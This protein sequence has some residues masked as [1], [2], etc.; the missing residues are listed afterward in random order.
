MT[1]VRL[2][3]VAAL[4]ALLVATVLLVSAAARWVAQRPAFEFKRIEVRGDLQHVTAASVRAAIAAVSMVWV[5]SR[6]GGRPGSP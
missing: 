4:A 3:N 6:R 5:S 2:M 1:G